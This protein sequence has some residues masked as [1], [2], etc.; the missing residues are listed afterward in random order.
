MNRE[1]IDADL[2]RAAWVA[3]INVV[4]DNAVESLQYLATMARPSIARYRASTGDLRWDGCRPRNRTS[5]SPAERGSRGHTIGGDV[6]NA[7][8]FDADYG[9]VNLSYGVSY[10]LEDVTPS[11]TTAGP[12]PTARVSG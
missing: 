2:F 4:T 7:M 12:T 10:L 3:G 11:P 8:T 6:S 9:D 1:Q 5:E